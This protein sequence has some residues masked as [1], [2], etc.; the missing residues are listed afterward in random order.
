MEGGSSSRALRCVLKPVS[1]NVV[2]G[3]RGQRMANGRGSAYAVLSYSSPEDPEM[4]FYR[5][6]A[7]VATASLRRACPRRV[8]A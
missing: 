5:R 2:E 6:S 1:L 7:E 4:S 3:V 8:T